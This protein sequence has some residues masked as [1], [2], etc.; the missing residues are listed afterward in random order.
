MDQSKQPQRLGAILE[1]PAIGALLQQLGA[2][3]RPQN[4]SEW[5]F[6]RNQTRECERQIQRTLWRAERYARKLP[7][8]V[9]Q[10]SRYVNKVRRRMAQELAR[11]ALSIGAGPE[12]A[13]EVGAIAAQRFPRDGI[14]RAE[15]T[16]RELGTN[17]RAQGTNPRELG[18]NPRAQGTNPREKKRR[19]AAAAAELSEFTATKNQIR[20]ELERERLHNAVTGGFDASRPGN[21]S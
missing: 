11:W 17:P 18:T 1:A 21:V 20:Q 5:R 14:V 10:G 7:K 13:A 4:A 15:D 3:P 9:R 2:S 19:A 6:Y 16:P 12:L 8:H